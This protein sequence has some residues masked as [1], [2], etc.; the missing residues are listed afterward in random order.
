[1]GWPPEVRRADPEGLK[2]AILEQLVACFGPAA[3]N[4]EALVV[5]DWARATRIVTQ[6]DLEGPANHP[7]LGP[8]ILRAPHLGGR[9]RFAVSEAATVSP[10]LIEGALAAGE[11][12]AQAI[13]SEIV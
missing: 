8:D 7:D 2:R 4:P 13:L 3:A 9:V 12:A 5:Q 1:V 11:H 6:L 10:G